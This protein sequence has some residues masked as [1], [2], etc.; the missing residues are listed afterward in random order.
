[1]PRFILLYALFTGVVWGEEFG[2]TPTETYALKQELGDEVLFLFSATFH[3]LRQNAFTIL[4]SASSNRFQGSLR[5]D[6]FD[7]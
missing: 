1:M 2:L 6:G 7:R 3:P 4:G 5:S